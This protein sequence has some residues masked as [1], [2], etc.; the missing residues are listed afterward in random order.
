[1]MI[2]RESADGEVMS[3]PPGVWTG[4]KWKAGDY[5]IS[6][7]EH[8]DTVGAGKCNTTLSTHYP[9]SNHGNEEML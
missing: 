1:M 4:R 8:R 6:L 9:R 2:L 5:I 7:L 3:N